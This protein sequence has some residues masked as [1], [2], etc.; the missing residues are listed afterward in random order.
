[1]QRHTGARR[2]VQQ[3]IVCLSLMAGNGAVTSCHITLFVAGADLCRA[4]AVR[5]AAVTL[6]IAFCYSCP[7][8]R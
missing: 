1:M 2:A 4:P 3:G 5:L 6:K 8:L 7:V